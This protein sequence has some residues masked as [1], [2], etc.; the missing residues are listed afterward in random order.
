MR[1][2][3]KNSRSGKSGKLFIC[4]GQGSNIS[5]TPAPAQSCYKQSDS[6]SDDCVIPWPEAPLRRIKQQIDVS[7][8][9]YV[10][11]G[12]SRGQGRAACRELKSRGAIVIATSRFAQG[13]PVPGQFLKPVFI[14]QVDPIANGDADYLLELDLVVNASIDIFVPQVV[15]I[16]NNLGKPLSGIL[17]NAARLFI[18]TIF[19]SIGAGGQAFADYQ[20]A[21]DLVG[22]SHNIFTAKLFNSVN[23]A[24]DARVVSVSSILSI[25]DRENA[26]TSTPYNA[27]KRAL[28]AYTD[29]LISELGTPTIQIP[30]PGP[31]PLYMPDVRVSNLNPNLV[32]TTFP[33][34]TQVPGVGPYFGRGLVDP[35]VPAEVAAFAFFTN[36]ILGNP[37]ASD[38]EASGITARQLFE[39]KEPPLDVVVRNKSAT[40]L[41]N[42]F[43]GTDIF[44]AARDINNTPE[45]IEYTTQGGFG[46]YFLDETLDV[47]LPQTW[48]IVPAALTPLGV[49]AFPLGAP[50]YDFEYSINGGPF[51]GSGTFVQGAIVSLPFLYVTQVDLSSFSGTDVEIEVK[52]KSLNGVPV[53]G[54]STG[55]P[56]NKKSNKFILNLHVQ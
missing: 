32:R 7:G 39:M 13:H 20:Q 5:C 44:T 49:F 47:F 29:A 19:D 25:P 17:N 6:S 14:P 53:N 11:T 4:S 41:E 31:N 26:G 43:C 50:G 51:M 21:T 27:G 54:E 33:V 42:I 28:R 46:K 3:A 18:G 55:N 37:R 30:A 56:I 36:L 15:G 2:S 34:P 35:N 38:P 22:Q 16:L 48:D 10:V 9:V 8:R 40:P 52:V 12:G 23:I 24:S 45:F 1:F